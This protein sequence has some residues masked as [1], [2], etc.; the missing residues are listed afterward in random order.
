MKSF[1][2]RKNLGFIVFIF[3]I[4]GGGYAIYQVSQPAS[5]E[6]SINSV[7]DS[8]SNYASAFLVSYFSYEKGRGFTNISPFIQKEDRRRAPDNL[9]KTEVV[10]VNPIEHTHLTSGYFQTKQLLHIRQH[11][12]SEDEREIKLE[13]QYFV[14]TVFVM[15]SPIG[16]DIKQYPALEVYKGVTID[17]PFPPAASSEVSDRMKP[18][19]ETFFKSYF[20]SSS[21][22]EV[23]SFFISTEDIQPLSGSLEYINIQNLSVY[24]EEAPFIV[25]ATVTAKE[26]FSGVELLLTYELV[27]VYKDRWLIQ[28]ITN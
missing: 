5:Y 19:L 23:A 21:F 24:N 15:Y 12:L 8:A 16:F 14:A 6:G 2:S 22:D 11:K 27:M 7:G 10:S 18:M 25:Y 13:D 4:L 9:M 20:S 3:A 28:S 26:P 17:A 1:F